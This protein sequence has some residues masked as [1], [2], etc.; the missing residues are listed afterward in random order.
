MLRKFSAI[1]LALVAIIAAGWFALR[2]PDIPYSTLESRYALPD[3]QFMTG[4]GDV[5]LHYTDTGPR[6]APVLM[7]VHG[8]AASLH[9][10][11]PW[12]KRLSD[13][14]RL[15]S[16][17]LPGHGLSHMPP[18][19][20]VSIE[21]YVETVAALAAQLD[22]EQFSL[23][24]SSM[25]GNVAWQ[26]ARA[27]PEQLDSLILVDAAGWPDEPGEADSDPLIFKLLRFPVA[28]LLMRDLDMG[29][30]IEDGLRKSFHDESFAT[31]AMAQRYSD[32][33]RAPGHR[34][35]LL[36]LS[37]D[38]AVREKASRA[39]LSG[40]DVPTLILW[41][42]DDNII[43]AAHARRFERAIPGAVA[44]TYAD[45][46]H[47]PQEEVAVRSAEDVRAF[48]DR[49]VASAQSRPERPDE[50]GYSEISTAVGS[51]GDTSRSGRGL[52]PR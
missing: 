18:D 26:Y 24:G 49:N 4:Q 41:G 10:W 34:A 36:K 23:A 3:S 42:E 35:A 50:G 46:G 28:R 1:L 12:Q 52:R 25:G 44:I 20:T 19:G 17:D 22:V 16:L 13:S 2:Q 6:D 27:Y 48:L 47:I 45:T 5:R 43:P 9:T 51:A 29:G 37:A 21:Y 14:Y 8:Y 7:L 15:I 31:E 11:Q 32:L 38:G 40:I 30:L 39:K 33:S